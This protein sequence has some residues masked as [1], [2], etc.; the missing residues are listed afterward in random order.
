MKFCSECAHPLTVSV[1]EGDNRPRFVCTHC[2]TIH[3]Q[4]PKMVIGSIPVWE[5]DGELK[6]LLCKRAIEPRRGL[7]TVPAGFMENGETTQ[8]GAVRETLEEANARVAIGPLYTI[9]SLPRNSPSLRLRPSWSVRVKGPPTVPRPYIRSSIISAAVCGSSAAETLP[10]QNRK[11]IK[12][13]AC[14]SPNR[15]MASF[16]PV[17]R[18]K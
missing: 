13:S 17:K 16:P 18:R 4:N 14:A 6:V 5:Q 9:I 8:Q 3:Y 10:Q 12:A 1:P 7:W 11:T 15:G 2:G